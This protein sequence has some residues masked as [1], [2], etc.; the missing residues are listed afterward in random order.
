MLKKG[1]NRAITSPRL[2]HSQMY[3][4]PILSPAGINEIPIYTTSTVNA[5]MVLSK[6]TSEWH[7]LERGMM[8]TY[9]DDKRQR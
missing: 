7:T 1:A 5:I 8:Y 6:F 4:A 2:D 9:H 3:V